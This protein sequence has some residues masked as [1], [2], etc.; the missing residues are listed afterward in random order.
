MDY[1]PHSINRFSKAAFL[2]LFAFPV[3]AYTPPETPNSDIF[4]HFPSESEAAIFANTQCDSNDFSWRSTGV[5]CSNDAQGVTDCLVIMQYHSTDINDCSNSGSNPDPNPDPDVPLDPSDLVNDYNPFIKS[6]P[7]NLSDGN[8]SNAG[9]LKQVAQ[10]DWANVIMLDAILQ[11]TSKLVSDNQY[12]RTDIA[13]VS[14]NTQQSNVYLDNISSTTNATRTDS[15]VQH[16]AL[17][18]KLTDVQLQSELNGLTNSNALTSLKDVDVAIYNSLLNMKYDT[19]QIA[20]NAARTA[21]R[22]NTLID[23]V[24]NI[25]SVG[26][27]GSGNPSGTDRNI[28]SYFDELLSYTR[29]S[30]NNSYET[31]SS[32]SSINSKLGS[33]SNSQDSIVTSNYSVRDEVTTTTEAVNGASQAITDSISDLQ[34]TQQSQTDALLSAIA[35]LGSGDGSGDGDTG[36]DDSVSA[37]PCNSGGFVCSGNAVNCYIA[38][39]QYEES[40]SISNAFGFDKIQELNES[41]NTYNNEAQSD[42]LS[43]DAGTVDTTAL[44]S[45]YTDGSGFSTSTSDSCPA[46]VPINTP[47]YSFTIDLTPLCD[48][49]AIVRWFLIAFSTVSAGLMISKYA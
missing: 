48:M 21:D 33:I 11:G 17:I 42:P 9:L 7:D 28:G 32:L 27:G 2:V 3:F 29:N 49:A 10:A 4:F 37:P 30:Q 45:K 40:C 34:S 19:G 15:Q 8:G 5:A 1:R 23:A 35:A 41:L 13:R 18:Q 26:G 24:N 14:S 46:P 38:Q 44:L 16:N 43:T 12:I 36:T 39:K 6:T 47:V 22:M 20:G 31:N 25:D